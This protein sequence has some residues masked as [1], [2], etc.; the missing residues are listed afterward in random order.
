MVLSTVPLVGARLPW[1][2][3]SDAAER[4][5]IVTADAAD[6]SGVAVTPRDRIA[7]LLAAAHIGPALAVTVLSALLAVAAGLTPGEAVLVI[8]AV[9]AGQLS[10]GWSNDLIDLTRDRQVGRADKPLVSGAVPVGWVRAGCAAAVVACVPLSLACGVAAGLVHLGCV[11]AGWAYNL[12]LKATVW[13]WL[14]YAVAFGGLTGFVSLAGSPDPVPW[15]WPVGGALLG[16]AAHLLNV[17]PDLADDA[18][19]GVEGLPHRLGKRWIPIVAVGVL[20]GASAAILLGAGVSAVP[21]VLAGSAVLGL[22]AV[23]LTGRG[24]LP[25]VAAILIALVDVVLLVVAS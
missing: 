22:A 6:T 14:P 8:A 13:S 25:F 5:D 1:V 7:G 18:A 10:I 16:V 11:A 3:S 21:T 4:K 15:W 24:R 12:R 23:V 9:L 2:P 20:V 17:L 19:T